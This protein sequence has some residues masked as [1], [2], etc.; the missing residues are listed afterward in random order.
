MA[1]GLDFRQTWLWSQA[2]SNPR[3]DSSTEEQE[4]FRSQYLAMRSK[5]EQLVS[6]IAVDMPGMTVHDITHRRSVG[7][8]LVGGRR[9]GQCEP[10][11]S[12]RPGRQ[13]PTA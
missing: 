1:D 8:G 9:R 13:H 3:S 12:L 4:Y 7:N 5:V 2:F 6:R 11:R 10:A